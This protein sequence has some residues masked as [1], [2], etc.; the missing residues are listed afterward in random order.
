MSAG[1]ESPHHPVTRLF[2]A[3]VAERTDLMRLASPIYHVHSGA[4]PF[5]I[6]HGTLDETVPFEQAERLYAAL[7]AAGVEAKLLPLEGVYHNWTP[8]AENSPGR[9]DTWKLGPMAL[10]FF[11]RHLC[12]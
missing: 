11:Q 9:E 6:A 7:V 12:P 2:G 3:T 5:L 10:P 4:P 8:Q 1:A